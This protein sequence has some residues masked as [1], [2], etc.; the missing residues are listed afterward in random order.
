MVI[1]PDDSSAPITKTVET[2]LPV[3]IGSLVPAESEPDGETGTSG[4]AA[5]GE[6]EGTSAA[7]N[8]APDSEPAEKRYFIFDSG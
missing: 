7:D 2:T 4:P 8:A 6:T 3:R 1:T 5:S